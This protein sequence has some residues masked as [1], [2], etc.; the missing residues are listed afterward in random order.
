MASRQPWVLPDP[1]R[2]S[3][4][5]Q[6]RVGEYSGAMGPPI[7]S[8]SRRSRVLTRVIVLSEKDEKDLKDKKGPEAFTFSKDK[9]PEGVP[10]E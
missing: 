1:A 10:C 3:Q 5:S 2:P 4:N 8:S 6:T 7:G 9:D